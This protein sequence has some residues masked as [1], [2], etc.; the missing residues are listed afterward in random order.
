MGDM[1]FIS[2]LMRLFKDRS[3]DARETVAGA[4]YSL[5]LVQK[6]RRFI[7]EEENVDIVLQLFDL[8]EEN[9]AMKIHL[10]FALMTVIDSNTGRRKVT[11]PAYLT[12]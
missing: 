12:N 3:F 6:W 2:E 7:Q 10:L 11:V 4:L 1:R 8:K 9:T 5:V